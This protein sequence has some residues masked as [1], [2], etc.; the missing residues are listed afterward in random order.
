MRDIVECVPNFS[1]GRDKGVIEK[2]AGAVEG[3]EG[4]KLLNVES[5]ADYNRTVV[6]F[7]GSAGAVVD[8]AFNATKAAAELIDMRRH[9]GGHPRIGAAD[10]VPF[11]PVSGVTMDDCIAC[12][13]DYGRRI[14]GELSIPVYLYEAA[15]S[16]PERS[17]LATVR[18]GQ[19]EGLEKKLK[20]PDWVPDFGGAAFNA[21]SGATVTGARN[22]L[23]AYNV[24]LDTDDVSIANEIAFVLRESGRIKKDSEGKNIIGPDGG[25]E[26]IPGR[27]K[28]VKAIG[29]TMPEYGIAQVSM[30]LCDFSLVSMHDVFL[31]CRE[32][33]ERLGASVTGSEVVG[34]TPMSALIRAGRCFRDLAGGSGDL[35]ERELVDLAVRELGLSELAPFIPEEKV[36]ELMIG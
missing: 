32:E 15:A 22:F 30:N 19:Y 24:N 3:S 34:L 14:A 36:I 35:T 31:A 4:A 8:A 7:I 20:D 16:R 1:E 21:R 29:V 25:A 12:A 23:I 6:T 26:R 2:I 27:F 33:A 11:I 28:S 17:N 9:K 5:D 10:V 13:K 18:E